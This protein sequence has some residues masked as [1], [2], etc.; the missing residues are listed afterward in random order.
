MVIVYKT[1]VSLTSELKTSY[2]SR[3]GEGTF[4]QTQFSIYFVE[5]LLLQLASR[6]H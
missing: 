2:F 6:L 3:L 5:Q 1:P 4:R